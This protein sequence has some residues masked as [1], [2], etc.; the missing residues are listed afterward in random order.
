M[1][2]CMV[3]KDKVSQSHRWV[4]IFSY[5]WCFVHVPL[6]HGALLLLLILLLLL[7]LLLLLHGFI[8]LIIFLKKLRV[9]V[10]IFK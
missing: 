2:G 9:D 5:Q 7:L 10:F 1:Y 8:N 3:T 6:A 4:T